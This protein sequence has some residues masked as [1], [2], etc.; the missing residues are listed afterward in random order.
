MKEQEL[1]LAKQQFERDK[2]LLR[3]MFIPNQ[4]LKRQRKHIYKKS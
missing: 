3:T 2:S 1:K 4:I